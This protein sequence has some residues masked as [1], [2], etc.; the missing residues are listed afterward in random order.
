MD[1]SQKFWKWM[2]DHLWGLWQWLN[3]QTFLRLLI[4]F[5]LMA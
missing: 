5:P 2:I 4:A 1:V 3:R